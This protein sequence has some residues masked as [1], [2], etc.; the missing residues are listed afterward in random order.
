[1]TATANSVS[2]EAGTAFAR[3]NQYWRGR[4]SRIENVLSNVLGSDGNKSPEA[5]FQQINRWAQSNGGNF[6]ALAQTM[7]SLPEDEANTVRATILDRMGNARAGA[8]NAD[9]TVFS[10]AEFVTQWN[11]LSARAKSVL[12]PDAQHR[13]DINALAQVMD[14]MKRSATY[15]NHSKTGIIGG[16]L[17]AMHAMSNPLTG[18]PQLLAEYGAGKI[19]SSPKV[20]RFLASRAATPAEL[21]AIGQGATQLSGGRNVL[22][23]SMHA[24]QIGQKLNDFAP[25]IRGAT[26]GAVLSIQ[27]AAT[28]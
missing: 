6:K 14:G 3:V 2:P 13:A 10:P 19:M 22:G 25:A 4:Q 7:R 8:Q 15:N 18:I 28:N 1:M 27:D 23:G 17:A 26:T 11:N 16:G 20:A 12:F 24:A 9:G 21:T 5:A